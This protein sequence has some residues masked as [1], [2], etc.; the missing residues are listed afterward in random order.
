MTI[1][2]LGESLKPRQTL[3][4]E[5]KRANGETLRVPLLCRIG[6]LDELEYFRNDGILPY[7]L[8]RLAA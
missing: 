4:A 5:V 7:V 3:N 6:A 1:H 2:G 8:R